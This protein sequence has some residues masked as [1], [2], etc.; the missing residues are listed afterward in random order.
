MV[1]FDVKCKVFTVN[2]NCGCGF[3]FLSKNMA[4]DALIFI[5]FFCPAK[6]PENGFIFFLVNV[7]FRLLDAPA[8]NRGR[9]WVS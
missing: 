5:T 9:N 7:I 2:K 6:K 4:F 8:N 3:S 1:K